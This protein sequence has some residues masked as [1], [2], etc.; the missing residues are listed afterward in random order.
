M[1]HD[2]LNDERMMTL[3]RDALTSDGKVPPEVLA[4]AYATFTWRTIDGE[5]AALT[6][7]STTEEPA[8][9]GARSQ[10]AG[11]RA[12]TFVSDSI[13]I[14]VEVASTSLLGQ[15]VPAQA[16]EVF[17]SLQD[18]T[19]TPVPVD[20]FGCFTVDPIPEGRFRLHVAG[21]PAVTTD[22]IEL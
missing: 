10:Q 8:L 11:L 15:L 21:E 2:W 14:E 20:E 9:S 3:V 22:W 5:L 6:Y 18:G 13:T 17:L 16:G 7:D 12:M 4:A 19:R 1:T